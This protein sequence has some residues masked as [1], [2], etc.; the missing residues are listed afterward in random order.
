[1]Y[2]RCRDNSRPAERSSP[3]ETGRGISE[4]ESHHLSHGVRLTR[5]IPPASRATE[6][7]YG[8]VNEPRRQSVKARRS[9]PRSIAPWRL[10]AVSRQASCLAEITALC[11]FARHPPSR[12]S[13]AQRTSGSAAAKRDTW[14]NYGMVC[15]RGCSIETGSDA[16]KVFLRASSSS[17]S[18]CS[19]SVRAR[20]SS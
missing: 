14:R 4:F 17:S 11:A 20:S 9:W 5:V 2:L 10:P 7:A 13:G 18:W 16:G 12:R 6:A 8:S 19:R 15:F 1:M 3:P